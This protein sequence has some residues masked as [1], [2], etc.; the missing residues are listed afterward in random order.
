MLKSI[1]P[2][3]QDERTTFLLKPFGEQE[4]ET[5]GIFKIAKTAEIKTPKI[6]KK[7]KITAARG[8]I[9]RIEKRKQ[10]LA[11]MEAEAERI[12]R[13]YNAEAPSAN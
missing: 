5:N 1:A 12:R 11:E 9:L 7:Q 13:S 10:E 6:D 2:I 4:T 3:P 8:A